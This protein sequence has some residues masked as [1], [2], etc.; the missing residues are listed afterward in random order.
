[1]T[2]EEGMSLGHVV[3]LVPRHEYYIKTMYRCLT[4][5]ASRQYGNAPVPDKEYKP[6]IR[7]ASCEKVV[8]HEFV[9]LARVN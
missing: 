2:D 3:T 8:R 1:M 6:M 4:C 9:E 5:G 7:C